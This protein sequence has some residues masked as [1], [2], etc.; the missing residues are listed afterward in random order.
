MRIEMHARRS[1]FAAVFIFSDV[2]A[3]LGLTVAKIA[4]HSLYII[5]VK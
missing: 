4:A 3:P 1:F 2:A 5:H